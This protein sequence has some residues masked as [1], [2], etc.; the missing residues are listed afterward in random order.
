MKIMIRLRDGHRPWRDYLNSDRS[1][2][3]AITL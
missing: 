2:L 1:M 3:S